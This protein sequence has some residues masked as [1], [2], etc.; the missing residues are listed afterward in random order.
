MASALTPGQKAAARAAKARRGE[1]GLSQ[2]RLAQLADVHFRTVQ[3]FERGR[4]WPQPTTMAKL[5]RM[6]LGWPVGKLA[7]LA[8]KYD[9]ERGGRDETA[10]ISEL[11]RMI[12]DAQQRIRELEDRRRARGVLGEVTEMRDRLD[13]IEPPPPVSDGERQE[14]PAV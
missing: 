8:A 7:D 1:L 10:E 11:H 6:G 13:R 9:E 14:P 3:D 12:A 5:E 2:R 4:T